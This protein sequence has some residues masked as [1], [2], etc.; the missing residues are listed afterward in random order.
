[1]TLF[2]NRITRNPEAHRKYLILEGARAGWVLPS[3]MLLTE[4]RWFT[5]V[6]FE[7]VLAINPTVAVGDMVVPLKMHQSQVGEHRVQVVNP[8]HL[9][10]EGDMRYE[11]ITEWVVL[12]VNLPEQD[13]EVFLLQIREHLVLHGY[14]EEARNR[15][16]HTFWR[17]VNEAAGFT[18]RPVPTTVRL[19]AKWRVSHYDLANFVRPERLAEIQAMS[20]EFV[21]SHAVTD[22]TVL[23]PNMSAECRCADMAREHAVGTEATRGTSFRMF[24]D[25]LMVGAKA[26]M[27]L[28][29]I[30]V[31]Q[32]NCPYGQP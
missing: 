12:P 15:G 7:S 19:R 23:L 3:S 6:L 20:D 1:M 27:E 32:I 17:E 21:L 22:H 30:E 10:V 5:G 18:L 16:W 29:S 13:K 24:S 25:L 28:A 8:T 14:E 26:R 2:T 4:Q 11:D 31:R 9:R